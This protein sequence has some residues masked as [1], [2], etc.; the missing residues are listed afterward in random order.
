MIPDTVLDGLS[1]CMWCKERVGGHTKNNN[2]AHQTDSGNDDGM[3]RV[4][5][6]KSLSDVGRKIGQVL[7]GDG[8]RSENIGQQNTI[9]FDWNKGMRYPRAVGV[10]IDIHRP[11]QVWRDHHHVLKT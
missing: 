3:R 7:R 8:F 2:I 4:R 10:R 6:N 9:D 5:K 1:R 11:V